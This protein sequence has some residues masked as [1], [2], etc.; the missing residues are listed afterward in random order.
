MASVAFEIFKKFIPIQEALH[1]LAQSGVTY[2][3]EDER[4]LN[5]L[6]HR[7]QSNET[8]LGPD[9]FGLDVSIL[10]KIFPLIYFLYTHYFRVEV[11]GSG[12]IPKGPVVFVANHGGQLPL[13][14]IMITAAV[15]LKAEHPRL[16]RS[17]VEKWVPTLPFVSELF[18]AMGQPTGTPDN[19]RLLAKRGESFLI[20]PE[21]V[22][23]ISKSFGQ[24]YHLVDFPPGFLRLAHELKMPV[25]PVAVIGAEEQFPS[26][27]N[28]LPL[29]RLIK[30]PSFPITPFFPWLGVLGTVPLPTKYRIYFGPEISTDFDIANLEQETKK[31]KT[32]LQGLLYRGLAQRKNIFW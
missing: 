13:D 7:I 14:A 23:G 12:N 24:R 17:M 28:F 26:F 27:G 19:F 25:I 10:K 15:A 8:A 21:G 18:Q 31:L 1:W 5:E 29:A 3:P 9:P 20:F 22:K 4:Q 16:L 11:Q 6:L 30:F 32:T 2:R